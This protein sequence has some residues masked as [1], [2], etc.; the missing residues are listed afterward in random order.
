MDVILN[1]GLHS[2]KLGKIPAHQAVAAVRLA[3]IDVKSVKVAQSDTE[4]TLV[5]EAAMRGHDSVE[6]TRTLRKLAETLGQDCIAVW[7][8]R[9]HFGA[10]IGPKAA[11]WGDFNPEFFILP[12]G[13][14]LAEPAAKAA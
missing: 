4:P 8:P 5:L 6:N 1:I 9:V 7:S 12:D 10:L 14:R 13:T 11:A 2:D 3:W